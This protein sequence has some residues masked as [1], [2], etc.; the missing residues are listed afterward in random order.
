MLPID[1]IYSNQEHS[2]ISRMEFIIYTFLKLLRYLT[3]GRRKIMLD[4]IMN[5][6]QVYFLLERLKRYDRHTYDHS[7][8]VAQYAL[9]VANQF[10]FSEE[11]KAV[12]F[13]SALLHDIGK[14]NIPIKIL[15]KREMLQKNEW[16]NVKNHPQQGVCILEKLIDD[17]L[18][19][20]DIILYHHENLDGSGYFGINEPYLSLSVRILRVVDSFDAMTSLRSYKQA[21]L[22]N[23]AFEELYRWKE[24]HFDSDVVE[25]LYY[26]LVKQDQT[27]STMDETV[28]IK[29]QGE[30]DFLRRQLL[31]EYITNQEFTKPSIIHISDLLDKKINEYNKIKYGRIDWDPVRLPTEKN[32]T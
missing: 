15:N 6:H 11:K 20:R 14:L 8:R 7:K 23:E 24:I 30:I 28:L 5:N 3:E 25:K 31:L 21:K 18:V 27:K 22:L 1:S 29:L 32:R 17:G 13:R 16:Q 2:V 4:N 9:D 26:L 19:D 12:L 10:Y